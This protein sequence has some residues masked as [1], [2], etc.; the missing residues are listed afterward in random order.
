M[1]DRVE[2]DRPD[3]NGLLHRR[4][5]IGEPE[6]FQQTQHVHILAP[7]MLCHGRLHQATQRGEFPGQVAAL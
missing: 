5:Q 2:A 7:A 4:M 1:F 3:L 6:A